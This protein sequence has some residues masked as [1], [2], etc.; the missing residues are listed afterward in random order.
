MEF[1]QL[2]L[3][4]QPLSLPL[5]EVIYGSVS[6]PESYRGRFS[7]GAQASQ[8]IQMGPGV[9][10]PRLASLAPEKSQLWPDFLVASVLV[11]LP[12]SSQR[13]LVE[14]LAI[15]IIYK[16]IA[17]ILLFGEDYTFM[18]LLSLK[19]VA[20]KDIVS[21]IPAFRYHVCQSCSS[22]PLDGRLQCLGHVS[23][24]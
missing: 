22:L 21:K 18:L 6:D 4:T 20:W 10:F 17:I 7:H 13:I 12:R 24:K 23:T 11:L 14:P 1:L 5:M 2:I 9:A 15:Q 16:N 8:N 3:H 19:V